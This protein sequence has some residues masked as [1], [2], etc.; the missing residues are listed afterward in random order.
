M[1]RPRTVRS[2]VVTVLVFAHFTSP[3]TSIDIIIKAS[4]DMFINSKVGSLPRSE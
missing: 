2:V 3:D 4:V 1:H